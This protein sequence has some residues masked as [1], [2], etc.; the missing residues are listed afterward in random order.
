MC[1]IILCQVHYQI[2]DLKSVKIAILS[3]IWE[4][5]IIFLTNRIIS[6]LTWKQNSMLENDRS[7][8]C[9][10]QSIDSLTEFS[11]LR[12]NDLNLMVTLLGRS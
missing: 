3:W 4:S 8:G 12:N 7:V 10:S 6:H 2:R 9:S 11:Q 5:A 1:Q